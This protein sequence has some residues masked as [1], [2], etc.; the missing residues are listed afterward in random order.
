MKTLVLVALALVSTFPHAATPEQVKAAFTAQS[1]C[2]SFSRLIGDKLL[3]G[4][5]YYWQLGAD[6]RTPMP[7]PLVLVDVTD[8]SRSVTVR[9]QD[10]S[11]DAILADGSLF[12]LTFNALEERDPESLKLIATHATHDLGRELLFKEHATRMA[13]VGSKLF[14][15]HGRLGVTVFDLTSRTI[16]QRI[17]LAQAQAPQESMATGIV[18]DGNQLYV[19][20]DNFTLNNPDEKPAFRGLIAID[21]QTG[22]VTRELEGLDPGTDGLW[23]DGTMLFVSYYG[24]PLWKYRLSD[25][26]GNKLPRPAGVIT[27]FGVKGHPFGIGFMDEKYFHTCFAQFPE[28]PGENNQVLRLPLSLERAPLKL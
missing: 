15:S 5:G 12:V 7:S 17:P 11:V 26:R 18:A 4:F 21:A 14:I 13:Q 8:A 9:T 27:N 16:T 23:S 10:A 20:M 19:S 24:F 25:L 2:G 3:M 28:N 6:Q 1:R 22:R